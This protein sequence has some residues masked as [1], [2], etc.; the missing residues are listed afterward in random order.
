MRTALEGNHSYHPID[1]HNYKRNGQILFMDSSQIA[2]NKS[3][4]VCL[5]FFTS[6]TLC[7]IGKQKEKG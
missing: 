1:L 6:V 4:N 7:D 3:F 2:L 5:F